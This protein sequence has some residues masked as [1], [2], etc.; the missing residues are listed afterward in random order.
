MFPV[1]YTS[2]GYI[3]VKTTVIYDG[4]PQ[5]VTISAHFDLKMGP[6]ARGRC[7]I[8]I[9]DVLPKRAYESVFDDMDRQYELIVQAVNMAASPGLNNTRVQSND[10]LSW[11]E[12]DAQT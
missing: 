7:D 2:D 1:N 4:M 12:Y 8:K 9:I 10:Y 6:S 11:G 5:K 3:E